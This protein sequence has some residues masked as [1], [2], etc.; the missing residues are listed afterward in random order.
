MRTGTGKH[1]RGCKRYGSGGTYQ[2]VGLPIDPAEIREQKKILND[3]PSF[4]EGLGKFA[5]NYVL[6]LAAGPLGNVLSKGIQTLLPG[7]SMS[8]GGDI[9][10]KDSK[11]GTF[12]SAAEEHHKSVQAFASQ[13]LANKEHYSSAMVKKANFAHN[14]AKW[15]HA[16]GGDLPYRL[17]ATNP[18]TNNMTATSTVAP[19]LPDLFSQVQPNTTTVGP[20]NFR[21]LLNFTEGASNKSKSKDRYRE[22]ATGGPL[23]GLVGPNKQLDIVIGDH[24]GEYQSGG[25]IALSS[26]AFQVQGKPNTTDGNYYPGLNARL[27]HNEVITNTQQGKFVYSDDLKDPNTNKSF[28][29]MAKRHELAKGKAE[30]KLLLNSNDEQAKSTISQSNS[31]LESL[32]STQEQLANKEGFRN[33]DGST[34]QKFA[35]GG[36]IWGGT[37]ASSEPSTVHSWQYTRPSHRWKTTTAPVFA[38]GGNLPYDGFDV[39]AFQQWANTIPGGSQISVDGIYGPSTQAL[40]KSLGQQWLQ[41][42][43]LNVIPDQLGNRSL[44]TKNNITSLESTLTPE[45]KLINTQSSTYSPF[46]NFSPLPTLTSLETS[47]PGTIDPLTG[48]QTN[49]SMYLVDNRKRVGAPSISNLVPSNTNNGNSITN[50]EDELYRTPWT[51]GDSLKMVELV[52]KGIGAFGKPELEKPQLDN[53]AIT[54][55][56]YDPT[57][58]LQQSNASLQ[59]FANQLG[60]ASLNTRRALLSNALS[61]KINRD[62]DVLRQYNQMNQSANTAFEQRAQAQRQYNIAQKNRASEINSMNLAA[63]DSV[64]QNFLTSIGQFG[65]DLN[66]KRFASDAVNLLQLQYPDVYKNVYKKLRYGK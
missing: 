1:K 52:G 20:I 7:S 53:S 2:P 39:K 54:K 10:I 58:Q 28:A 59:N 17:T 65:E 56:V 45:G 25:D 23:S 27:D 15:N 37:L 29:Y 22:R 35:K 43:N 21:R 47:V 32:A 55:E 33:P 66:R 42:Q 14:A 44:V 49:G 40:Y 5:T 18:L 64:T 6:P 8:T 34:K 51:F 31:L 48:Q 19:Q 24:R 41:S 26:N 13:V 63:Q 38:K 11:K 62:S 46:K 57:Q 30:K 3:S 36:P 16:T 12:T 9:H 60:S 61:S 4:L 50:G